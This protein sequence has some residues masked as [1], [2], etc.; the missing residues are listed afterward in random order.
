MATPVVEQASTTVAAPGRATTEP[1]AQQQRA[2]WA[3]LI[4]GPW[5]LMCI[6]AVQAV[7]SLR[8]VWSN[9]AFQDEA[10]YLWAGRMEWAHWL[11]GTPI[12]AFPTY[13]SGAP[14]IYPVLG[15]VANSIGGLAG[16]RMLSLCFML[17]ATALLWNTTSR[18]FDNRAGFFAAALFAVLGP[19]LKLG[20]F[21]T[22]DAMS[23]FLIALAAWCVVRAGSRR[24]ATRWMLAATCALVL[25]NATTYSSGI[26]DPVVI[27]LAF[28]VAIPQPGG[29]S[30][31][32]RAAE[33]LTY[34]AALLIALVKIAGSW[35]IRGIKQ[36]V[37]NRAAASDPAW[38][39]LHDAWTWTGLVV[40]LSVIAILTAAIAA[41]ER[42][43]VAILTVLAGSALLVPIEQARIHTA[44]SLDKHA[45]IGAWFAA[46]AAGY[47]VSKLSRL[48]KR[49][50]LNAAVTSV[51]AVALT[52]PA[53]MGFAQGRALFAKWPNATDFITAFRPIADQT[54]GPMLVET[55]SLA[56]YYL[57]AGTQ[58]QRWS[59]TYDIMRPDGIG[60]GA[61][62]GQTLKPGVYA[63]LIAR[64]WFTLVVLDGAARSLDTQIEADLAGNPA[65]H[66][67]AQPSYGTRHYRIWE[68]VR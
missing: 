44:T 66:E 33:I 27:A 60:F 37:L 55:P 9:T 20:A 67:V 23:L 46:I 38:L 68:R 51:C 26:F 12:P 14:V 18:L 19:T 1:E 59:S 15:A 3:L 64:G 17:G 16:A 29:K 24:D 40:I 62:V 36:T 7:L 11:H 21:A 10:L 31:K 52:I 6:L 57:P 35:Y 22:F 32:T 50:V 41:Q 39:V 47:V 56:E 5:P 61:G 63:G 28:L 2:P 42:S 4:S 43:R 13:F 34:S 58:W 49:P 48:P 30:A 45:D 25:G 54:T 53:V 8:L 65:Y